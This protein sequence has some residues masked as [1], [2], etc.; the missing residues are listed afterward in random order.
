MTVQIFLTVWLIIQVMFGVINAIDLARLKGLD[1]NRVIAS[2]IGTII[3][4]IGIIFCLY[5]GGFYN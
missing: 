3:K 5:I 1:E 2:A 4:F